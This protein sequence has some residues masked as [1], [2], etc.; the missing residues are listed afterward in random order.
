ME[1]DKLSCD[2]YAL[3]QASS[4]SFCEKEEEKSAKPVANC[5]RGQLVV[6]RE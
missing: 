2:P 6:A 1:V 4:G 5:G 3:S